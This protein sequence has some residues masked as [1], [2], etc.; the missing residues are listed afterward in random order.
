MEK[1]STVGMNDNLDRNMLAEILGIERSIA[2]KEAFEANQKRLLKAQRDKLT[3]GYCWHI[4][5][6]SFGNAAKE[7]CYLARKS[8]F[9]KDDWWRIFRKAFHINWPLIMQI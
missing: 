4:H 9:E 1:N 7:R 6:L 2:T 5:S 3:A 8:D